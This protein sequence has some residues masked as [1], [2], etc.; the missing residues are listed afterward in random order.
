M[1][2]MELT[3]FGQGSWA[4][5]RKA[6]EELYFEDLRSRYSIASFE[7]VVEKYRVRGEEKGWSMDLFTEFYWK[8]LTFVNYLQ[9]NSLL[10]ARES[11]EKYCKVFSGE[12]GH[13]VKLQTMVKCLDK[14]FPDVFD[15]MVEAR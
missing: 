10:M 1:L 9:T 5:F 14:E 8:A 4:G 2:W 11:S 12:F 15:F 6:V 7:A 3:Q 13:S